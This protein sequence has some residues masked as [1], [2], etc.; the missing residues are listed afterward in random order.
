[1]L[2]EQQYSNLVS[3]L[4]QVPQQYLSSIHGLKCKATD[5]QIVQSHKEAGVEQALSR[6]DMELQ[7]V[8]DGIISDLFHDMTGEEPEWN[9]E[10]IGDLRDV[11]IDHL[12][13]KTGQTEYSFYPY[14]VTI[15]E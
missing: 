12:V 14:I 4:K 8:V 11:V 6:Y 3:L 7:D 13:E 2:D 15:G 5:E 1:M 9:M 10:I